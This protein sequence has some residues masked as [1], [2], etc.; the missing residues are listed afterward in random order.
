MNLIAL[1][2]CDINEVDTTINKTLNSHPSFYSLLEPVIPHAELRVLVVVVCNIIP[3]FLLL[4]WLH[5]C[6]TCP[7]RTL[8]SSFELKLKQLQI[9]MFKN[10]DTYECCSICMEDYLEGN[11]IRVLPCSHAFH[12]KCIDHWLTK[13]HRACP[14]C[15]RKV[16]PGYKRH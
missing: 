3:L 8:I 14:L 13:Y 10:G 6:Y 4:V 15:Q 7:S 9:H 5:I 1:S 12:C 2:L 16:F 11:E